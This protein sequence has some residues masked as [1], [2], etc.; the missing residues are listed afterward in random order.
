MTPLPSSASASVCS[1]YY[2]PRLAVCVAGAPSNDA[3]L[4]SI[5]A[6][7]VVALGGN[8]TTT[9]ASLV[10][11]ERIEGVRSAVSSILQPASIRVR[12]LDGGS[13][14][15]GCSADVI[16]RRDCLL[17]VAA[18]ERGAAAR[19]ESVLIVPAD[20]LWLLPLWPHCFHS[21][22]VNRHFGR[23]AWLTREAVDIMLAS[24]SH[25]EGNPDRQRNRRCLTAY[26]E[27]ELN[28]TLDPS[29]RFAVQLVRSSAPSSGS[30]S[31]AGSLSSATSMHASSSFRTPARP[32]CEAWR[33]ASLAWRAASATRIMRRGSGSGSEAGSSEGEGVSF[34]IGTR[35]PQCP[36]AIPSA[37][38]SAF[39]SATPSAIPSAIP[40][41]PTLHNASGVSVT[42]DEAFVASTARLVCSGSSSAPPKIAL[43]VGGLA[44]TF[45]HEL[46]HRSMHGH[47]LLRLGAS[48]SAVFAHLRL[49]DLRGLTGMHGKD[50]SAVIAASQASVERALRYLG[51]QPEDVIVAESSGVA[52]PQC[53]GRGGM[54]DRRASEQRE[55]ASTNSSGGGK[56][57]AS[58][59]GAYG[60][61]CS[62]HVID[63]MLVTRARLFSLV[64]AHEARRGIRFDLLLFT[65]PDLVVLLPMMPWCFY[66]TAVARKN[67]DWVEWLPR[68]LA[69]APLKRIHDD[70]YACML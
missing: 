31:R 69:E 68:A 23:V 17:Q 27:P 5:R 18:H 20:S 56:R 53:A 57:G 25:M 38:P 54:Y 3:A 26:V 52:P 49:G 61:A 28:S 35:H 33:A 13:S 16:S 12:L 40:S 15:G 2:S 22:S 21:G 41:A 63:G 6:N 39:P 59:C 4:R 9:F 66:D 70:Y 14:E 42:D 8:L 37:F 10:L 34:P 32:D 50:F 58:T 29:L 64:A 7:I 55:P 24:P 36:S 43:C 47:L 51:A 30:F 46:V 62:Q 65:R 67:Q 60:L 19:F 11:V 45:A 44:R 48:Y 1:A